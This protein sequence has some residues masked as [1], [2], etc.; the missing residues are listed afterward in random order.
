MRKDEVCCSTSLNA[1]D[2]KELKDLQLRT[3]CNLSSILRALVHQ[4]PMEQA[5]ELVLCQRKEEV[6]W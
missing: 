4:T 6:K 5:V 2:I 3:G 1:Q